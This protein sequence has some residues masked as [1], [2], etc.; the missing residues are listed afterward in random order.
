MDEYEKV[1]GGL[2]KLGVNRII[3]VSFGAD[4]TTWGYLNYIQKHNFQGGI[5]QPCPAVVGY[6]E[7]Y[8]PELLPKLF[9]VQSPMMCAAIYARKEMGIQDKLAFIS[10]CIAKKAEIEDSNNHGYVHYNVTFEHLMAYVRNIISAGSW[11]AM[12]LN[13][14][15][16]RFILCRGD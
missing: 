11:P 3:N 7:R 8:A 13:M 12:R 15:W 5:S 10:P 6:I 16:V 9:P 14:A 1:L 2:K 4:I